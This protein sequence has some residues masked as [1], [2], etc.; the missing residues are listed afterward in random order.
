MFE[1]NAKQET[2]EIE[3]WRVDAWCH[4]CRSGAAD[5][6]TLGCLMNE[7]HDS[8]RSLYEC[9][10]P[11]LDRLVRVCTEAGAKGARLTGAGWGGCVVALT[12]RDTVEEF[13]EEV[14]REFYTK[15]PPGEGFKTVSSPDSLIFPTEPNQG[16]EIYLP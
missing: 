12:T 8:L 14:K 6:T 11:T 13:I 7:S 10:H 9:S 5:L 3:A 16:A 2:M 4:E 15:V 1:K